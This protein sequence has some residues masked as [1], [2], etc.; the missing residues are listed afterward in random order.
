MRPVRHEGHDWLFALDGQLHVEHDQ[1]STTLRAGDSVSARVPHRFGRA[2]RRVPRG[3]H[4]AAGAAPVTVPTRVDHSSGSTS[5]AISST[6]D[7][8]P[9]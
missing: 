6:V 9:A 3:R 4:D 5:E 7:S 8:L 2:P 1:E